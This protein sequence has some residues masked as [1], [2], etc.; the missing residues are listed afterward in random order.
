[1]AEYMQEISQ[2]AMSDI[3]EAIRQFRDGQFK[4]ARNLPHAIAAILE[5]DIEGKEFQE[6]AVKHYSQIVNIII[7]ELPRFLAIKKD[8]SGKM[9]FQVDKDVVHAY[10]E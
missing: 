10:G 1:M 3:I 8:V 5:Y 6:F 4:D 2:Q 9:F 7:D